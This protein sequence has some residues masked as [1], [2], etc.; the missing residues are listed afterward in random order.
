MESEE[1]EGETGRR[2]LKWTC[3]G[4]G[5]PCL[6]EILI[7]S[8]CLLHVRLELNEDSADLWQFSTLCLLLQ[9]R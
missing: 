4:L 8:F 6:P 5:A 1:Q 9:V 3:H 7:I 2:R